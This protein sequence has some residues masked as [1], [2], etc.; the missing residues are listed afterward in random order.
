MQNLGATR[1]HVPQDTFQVESGYNQQFAGTYTLTHTVHAGLEAAPIKVLRLRAGYAF[2][3]SPYKPGQQYIPMA[4]GYNNVKNAFTMG[5][6][7][8]LKHFYADFAYVY[9]W[10]KDASVQ[11]SNFNYPVNSMFNTS[12]LLLTIGW[13]F[14]ANG[15][16]SNTNNQP[17]TEQR[18]Y[19]PPPVDNDQRY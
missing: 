4:G 16:K 8:R 18:R 19:T 13:K 12:T 9:A 2:S 15:G 5:I 6:G 1:I 10:S 3:S 17:K 7:L 11:L 14:D